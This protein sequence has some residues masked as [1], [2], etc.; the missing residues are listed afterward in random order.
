[1]L[2]FYSFDYVR[3]SLVQETLAGTELRHNETLDI[4]LDRL[5][6]MKGELQECLEDD[7]Q[8][9]E[10][11]E[12]RGKLAAHLDVETKNKKLQEQLEKTHRQLDETTRALQVKEQE[13]LHLGE[14]VD[15][16]VAELDLAAKESAQLKERA[17]SL[18]QQRNSLTRKFKTLD[19]QVE[20]LNAKVQD[21]ER[22]INS[23]KQRIQI[24]EAFNTKEEYVL[25][26]ENSPRYETRN[27][28]CIS[29]FVSS[30]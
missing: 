7:S 25:V 23:F 13:Y 9:V 18:S 12:L 11:A 10:A 4:L 16:Q 8:G 22:Q 29:P 2:G 21:Y 30:G 15:K 19:A 26:D 3:E 14:I 17:S 20:M 6:V 1:V 28:E 5:D 27:W 24:R